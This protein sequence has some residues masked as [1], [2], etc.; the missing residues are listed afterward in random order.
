MSLQSSQQYFIKLH[1]DVASTRQLQDAGLSSH[2]AN[3]TGT[4]VS[5]GYALSKCLLLLPN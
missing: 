4:N 5:I 1:S 2:E 3:I